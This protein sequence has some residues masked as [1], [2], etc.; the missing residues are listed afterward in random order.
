MTAHN[1]STGDV[2]TYNANGGTAIGGLAD[3][4]YHVIRV[5]EHDQTGGI[6]RKC[7]GWHTYRPDG[8][9]S[10]RAFGRVGL[11]FGDSLSTASDATLTVDGVT[12]RNNEL[13]ADVIPGVTQNLLPTSSTA[14]SQYPRARRS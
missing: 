9:D 4:T 1:Y 13:A 3:A 7:Y 2:I 11:S 8:T 10:A 5:D 12:I 14:S 6:G